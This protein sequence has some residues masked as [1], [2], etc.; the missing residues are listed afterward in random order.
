MPATA[1]NGPR[2]SI[3]LVEDDAF[4][5][6][7]YVA[8]LTRERYAVELA[9]DG[10]QGLDLITRVKPDLVL[11]DILLPEKNGWDVLAA[12]KKNPLTKGIPVL[13]LSNAGQRSDIENGLALGAVGYIVKVQHTPDEVVAKIDQILRRRAPRV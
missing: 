8:K 2:P 3:V 13:I 5:A 9:T 4:I 11:L 1:V 12:L 7:L 6:G 10:E